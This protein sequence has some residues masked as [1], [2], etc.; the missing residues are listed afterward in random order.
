MIY[1]Y[2]DLER[3]W[4]VLYPL[5]KQHCC[6]DRKLSKK[7]EISSKKII[8]NIFDNVNRMLTGL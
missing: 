5:L 2:E 4:C 6:S 1:H 7:P 8:S 3:Q